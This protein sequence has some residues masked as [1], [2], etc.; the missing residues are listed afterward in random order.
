MPYTKEFI[1]DIFL[2]E[3]PHANLRQVLNLHK[4]MC[5]SF[6]SDL[7]TVT[8]NCDIRKLSLL[9]DQQRWLFEEQPEKP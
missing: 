9:C 4:N 6:W 8:G 7:G 1:L 5:S 2:K 3:D